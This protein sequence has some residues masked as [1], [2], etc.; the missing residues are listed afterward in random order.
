MIS[1]KSLLLFLSLLSLLVLPS[2]SSLAEDGPGDACIFLAEGY[3]H[4]NAEA[5]TWSD[6][7]TGPLPPTLLV[8]DFRHFN[9]GDTVTIRVEPA[10]AAINPAASL[11]SLGIEDTGDTITQVI[12]STISYTFSHDMNTNVYLNFYFSYFTAPH[13]QGVLYYTYINCVHDSSGEL[14][15]SGPPDN[16]LNWQS[17]DAHIAI[18]FPTEN[19][20]DIFLYESQSYISNFITNEDIAAYLENPPSENVLIRSE[21]LV[22]VYILTTGEIQF[23][24]GPDAEG[25]TYT[26]RIDDLAGTNLEAE[27]FDPNE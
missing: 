13:A 2:F 7:S 10:T 21:G 6:G 1:R 14:A 9:A 17:G 16:R 22:S 3:D 15:P 18:L 11:F 24:L 26:I 27:Y 8:A 5:M 20:I 19:G 25:K 4:G 23:N 12:S